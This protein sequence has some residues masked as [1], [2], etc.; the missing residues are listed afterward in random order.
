MSGLRHAAILAYAYLD[1]WGYGSDAPDDCKKQWSLAHARLR[2][3]LDP[4]EVGRIDRQQYHDRRCDCG[5]IVE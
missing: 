1:S 2:A 4:D 5:A 3:A